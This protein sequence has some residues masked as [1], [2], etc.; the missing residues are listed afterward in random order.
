MSVSPPSKLPMPSNEKPIAIPNVETISFSNEKHTVESTSNK[1]HDFLTEL[2]HRVHGNTKDESLESTSKG[3]PR[4]KSNEDTANLVSDENSTRN[5]AEKPINADSQTVQ[6]TLNDIGL[7]EYVPAF[8]A[9]GLDNLE[10]FKFVQPSDLDD[11]KMKP[12]HR[13]KL[14]QFLRH[15]GIQVESF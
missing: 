12:I 8:S 9:L 10:D 2:K 5:F 7:D 4:S 1:P 6:S 3:G 11:M 15:Q 14:V 13:R